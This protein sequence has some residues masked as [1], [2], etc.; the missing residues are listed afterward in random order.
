MGKPSTL[1][2]SRRYKRIAQSRRAKQFRMYQEE[3]VCSWCEQAHLFEDC[4]AF[5]NEQQHMIEEGEYGEAE[6]GAA[7]EDERASRTQGKGLPRLWPKVEA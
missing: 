1:R 5:K 6:Q 4:Q 7:Q 3:L 2:P